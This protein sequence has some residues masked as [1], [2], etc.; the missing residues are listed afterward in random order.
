MV[1]DHTLATLSRGC[2]VVV[3]HEFTLF[4]INYRAPYTGELRSQSFDSLADACSMIS[5]YRECGTKAWLA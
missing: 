5:F 4:T 3:I 1:N 2:K